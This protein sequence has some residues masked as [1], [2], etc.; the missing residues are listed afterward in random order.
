[1]L[2]PEEEV[3]V[4][5]LMLPKQAAMEWPTPPNLLAQQHDSTRQQLQ[6][7]RH[8]LPQPSLGPVQSVVPVALKRSS[9]GLQQDYEQ[10]FQECQAEQMRLLIPSSATPAALDAPSP[11]T[12]C[13][14]SFA[15]SA[16]V[17]PW[18]S[19]S[20]LKEGEDANQIEE[21]GIAVLAGGGVGLKKEEEEEVAA[22][23]DTKEEEEVVAFI[24]HDM[25]AM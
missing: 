24:L 6:L 11:R 8:W 25:H 18:G 16:A 12:D 23:G 4:T 17:S 21:V 15:S 13:E 19:L 20:P 1:M 9:G 3:G 14:S 22:G 2:L 7:Q 10:L 5:R